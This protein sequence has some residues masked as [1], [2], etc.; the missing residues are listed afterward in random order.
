M[1]LHCTP[2]SKPFLHITKCFYHSSSREN[3][4]TSLSCQTLSLILKQFVLHRQLSPES[5]RTR[6]P[7]HSVTDEYRFAYGHEPHTRPKKDF[8]LELHAKAV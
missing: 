5:F 1:R 8:L 2:M 4:M 3:E 7:R 6:T